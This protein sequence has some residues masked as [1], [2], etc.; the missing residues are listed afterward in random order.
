[1][2]RLGFLGLV[3]V[4]LVIVL[5]SCS[6]FSCA[7]RAESAGFIGSKAASPQESLENISPMLV[8]ED[9]L[10]KMESSSNEIDHSSIDDEV[11]SEESEQQRMRVYNG[12]TGLIVEDIEKSRRNLEELARENGGYV[13]SSYSDYVVLRIPAESF[14]EVF[15][16]VLTMGEVEYSR[17]ETWDIT[18]AYADISRHLNTAE[19]TRRRLYVLLEKSTDPAERALILKEIGRLTE[20][21]ESLKQQVSLMESRVAFSRITVQL[22][23]RIQSDSQRYEIPFPWI[24]Y[25]DPLSPAGSQLRAHLEVD[26]GDDF[27]VFDKENIYMAENSCGVQVFVSTVD[28]NPRGDTEFWKKALLH[29]LTP[30]YA[31]V[32]EQS[33]TVGDSEFV[34]AEFLS[35]DREPYKYYIGVYTEGR[36]IHILEIFSPEGDDDFTSIYAA[37]AQGDLK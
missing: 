32:L 27:A 4:T 21:I 29:H 24:A 31:E 35:K 9:S 25:L 15:D 13:E 26:L 37:F 10:E 36:K 7:N 16:L 18:D 23:P 11:S 19:E 17:V 12:S 14:N 30:F 3:T 5:A 2:K 20:E 34:G 28:N 33:V 6:I 8:R 1:M 22:T